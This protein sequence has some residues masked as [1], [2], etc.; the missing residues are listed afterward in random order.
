M[1]LSGYARYAT[2]LLL[3]G[4][5]LRIA[6]FWVNPPQNAFDDHLEPIQL[7]M[8]WGGLPLT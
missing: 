5:G 2:L 1:R 6:R 3:L 8:Q 7:A 4:A